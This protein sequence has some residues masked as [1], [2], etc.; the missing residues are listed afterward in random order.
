MPLP[1]ENEMG[2]EQQP[3]PIECPGV[4]GGRMLPAVSNPDPKNSETC[5]LSEPEGRTWPLGRVGR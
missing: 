4:D 2:A 3:T 1:R 5:H